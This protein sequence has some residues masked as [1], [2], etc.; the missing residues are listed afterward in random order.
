M[1]AYA[2]MEFQFEKSSSLRVSPHAARPPRP[3]R[4]HRVRAI[5]P[6]IFPLVCTARNASA[7]SSIDS[8]NF[9]STSAVVETP[10]DPTPRHAF[11]L[12]LAAVGAGELRTHHIDSS[13]VIR[14]FAE[15]GPP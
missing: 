14:I 8:P 10:P 12:L 13:E 6:A 11:D 15:R 7:Q 2:P 1:N 5:G 9:P 4:A 3:L